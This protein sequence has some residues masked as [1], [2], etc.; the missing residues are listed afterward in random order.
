MTGI[1]IALTAVCWGVAGLAYWWVRHPVVSTVRSCACGW[2]QVRL[3]EPG[4]QH[5]G[6]GDIVH[7]ADYCCPSRE[8]LR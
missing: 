2:T 5:T 3:G 7:T 8:V 1:W 4:V 6:R